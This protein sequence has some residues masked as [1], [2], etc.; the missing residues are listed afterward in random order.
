MQ[1][2]WDAN[3]NISLYWCSNLKPILTKHFYFRR[4]ALKSAVCWF[5]STKNKIIQFLNQSWRKMFFDNKMLKFAH[6]PGWMNTSL[7]KLVF[8][9]CLVRVITDN[10]SFHGLSGPDI[11]TTTVRLL[12]QEFPLK[13]N[14][15]VCYLNLYRFFFQVINY[16]NDVWI[17]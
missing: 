5:L 4:T 3:F 1:W 9:C 13:L 8:A 6:T 2:N 10:V 11:S 7:G 17:L 12:S 15:N 14:N 16:Y